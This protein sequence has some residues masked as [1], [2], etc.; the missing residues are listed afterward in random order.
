VKEDEKM[1]YKM[2]QDRDGDGI[3]DGAEMKL[4]AT[5]QKTR[6]QA[7]QAIQDSRDFLRQSDEAAAGSGRAELPGGGLKLLEGGRVAMFSPTEA[8]RGEPYTRKI[9]DTNRWDMGVESSPS[10]TAAGDLNR[11]SQRNAE[12]RTPTWKLLFNA[13][14]AAGPSMD[15]RER[16]WGGALGDA[17]RARAAAGI[18]LPDRELRKLMQ[19]ESGRM[20]PMDL[21]RLGMERDV[22]VA[23]AGGK[24]ASRTF[25]EQR[26]AAFHADI[27][28]GIEAGDEGL[29][30]SPDK[31]MYRNRGDF[32]SEGGYNWRPLV[33][34]LPAMMGGGLLNAGAASAGGAPVAPSAPAFRE[35]Q[36][37]TGPKGKKMVYRNGGWVLVQP[38]EKG[39]PK[40]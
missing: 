8:A 33:T 20:D 11:S 34:G 18:G 38:I 1:A 17:G 27:E 40:G 37:A 36:T 31:K 10:V 2:M 13:A 32:T 9:M 22:A 39:V 23:E 30:Y 3:P 26:R 28:A 6:R 25:E 21:A 12:G 15:T 24:A 5:W 16:P 35:G 29:V 14:S 19:V 7:D 4:T